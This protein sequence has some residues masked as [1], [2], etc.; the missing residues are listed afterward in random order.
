VG[1]AGTSAAVTS[2][3]IDN[4]APS[5]V[6][7]TALAAPLGGSVAMAATATDLGSGIANVRIQYAPTG[8]TGWTDICTKTAPLY[9]C[10]FASGGVP[11]GVYDFRAFAT[12]NAGNTGASATQTRTVDNNGPTVT[13][14]TPAAGASVNGTINVSANA[15]DISGVASVQ[16]QYRQAGATLWTTLTTGCTASGSSYSCPLN[17]TGLVNGGTYELRFVAT[18]KA[19]PAHVTTT[20]VTTFTVDRT[21][22]TASDVQAGNGGTVGTLDAGDTLTFMFSEPMLPASIMSGWDGSATPVTV[23]VTEAGAADKLEIYDAANTTRTNVT[24]AATPL[25]LDADYVASTATYNGT[26]QRAGNNIVITFGT[27]TAGT[28]RTGAKKGKM[29]WTPSTSA[30]DMAG[31]A[32]TGGSVN[33]SGGNSDAEF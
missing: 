24:A 1:K 31:N 8:T 17:T 13:S 6:T 18:D 2:R 5:P 16:M 30:T 4:T 27:L 15:T 7:L 26:M 9:T 29:V 23:R 20:P 19:V 32:V 10:T 21:A 3:Q 11:D 33:E 14:T 12:D 22:P 28:R 25:N